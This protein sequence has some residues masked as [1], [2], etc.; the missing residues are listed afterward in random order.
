MSQNLQTISVVLPVF[1]RRDRILGAV[2]SALAQTVPLQEIVIV[3][4]GSTDG[5][6]E[7][8]FQAVDPRIR[9]IRLPGNEGGGVARTTGIDAAQG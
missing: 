4:D 1:N 8:D 3:D 9:L 2:N 7:I 5:I 6:E